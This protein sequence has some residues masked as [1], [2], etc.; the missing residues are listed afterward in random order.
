[1]SVD[2]S[3]D[4]DEFEDYIYYNY[5]YEINDVLHLVKNGY[6][7]ANIYSQHMALTNFKDRFENHDHPN[8][9]IIVTK[10]FDLPMPPFN[11]N[12]IVHWDKNPPDLAETFDR[13]KSNYAKVYPEGSVF[14]EKDIFDNARNSV[15]MFTDSL[16][17][18]FIPPKE[19]M[20]AIAYAFELY[21]E[22]AGDLSLESVFFGEP[23]KGAGNYSR[24]TAKTFDRFEA[25]HYYAV[26]EKNSYRTLEELALTLMRHNPSY[27]EVDDSL[28]RGYNEDN[29][30][31]FLRGYRR[32]K[33]SK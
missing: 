32:W 31:S 30:D 8:I 22:A 23:K 16:L 11:T 13:L 20:L 5:N 15:S 4:L 14:D 18:G 3:D 21:M 26:R 24:S 33:K 1:M 28:F 19:S 29:I 25:F 9:S 10:S 2:S 7:S 27:G 17:N 6:L 12:K